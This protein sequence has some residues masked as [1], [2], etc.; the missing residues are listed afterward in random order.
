[1]VCYRFAAYSTPLRTVAAWQSARFSRAD[2]DEPT[3]YLSLH[4]L[5]PLAELMRNADLRGPEQVAAVSTR[6]WALEVALEGLPEITFDSAAE[7]GIDA[8]ELVADDHGACQRLA[9]R[10]RTNLAGVI[11][12][13]AALPGTCNVVLFGPR[14]AAPYLVEPIAE[15][16]VPASITADHGRPPVSL[17][18][19]VRFAGD[20]HAALAAWQRGADFAFAEPDWSL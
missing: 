7:F 19:L 1:M 9:A 11:V 2:E 15:I 10:I 3:Q 16:D 8:E 13:S 5:G 6:T 18:S 14:V 20:P 17:R 4:P 12:P